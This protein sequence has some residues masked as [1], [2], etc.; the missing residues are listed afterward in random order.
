MPSIHTKVIIHEETNPILIHQ[1]VSTRLLRPGELLRP[2]VQELP[3][4]YSLLPGSID[5]DPGQGLY[6]SLHT[7]FNPL[8]GPID[9]SEYYQITEASDPLFVKKLES[10]PIG[11]VLLHF[12]TPY[13][14][15]IGSTYTY[16]FHATMVGNLIREYTRPLGLTLAWQNTGLIDHWREGPK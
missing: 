7:E 13:D 12:D 11:Y 1:W 15:S 10:Y 5:N 8:G 9:W 16:I 4:K 14:A 3:L 2:E 6:S